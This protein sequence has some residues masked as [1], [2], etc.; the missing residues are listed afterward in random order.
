[1][2]IIHITFTFFLGL[3]LTQHNLDQGFQYM[4][5]NASFLEDTEGKCTPLTV[6]LF[7]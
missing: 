5:H 7:V 1:M 6:P 4:L 3:I 2:F